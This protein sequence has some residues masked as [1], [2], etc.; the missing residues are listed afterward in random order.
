MYDVIAQQLGTAVPFAGHAGVRMDEVGDGTATARLAQ[1][2][3]SVNHLGTQHA[4][5]LFTLGEA[6]S[7]GAMAGA[8]ASVLMQA[9]P[10][11]ASAR[12]DYAKAAKGEIT[13]RARTGRPGADILAELQEAKRAVFDVDVELTNE[14]GVVVATM[15]VGWNVRLS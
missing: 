1:T 7:G 12:I 11:A 15:T 10:V 9:R 2:E 8:I 13:A 5:A 3:T 14:D 6:A 4:G